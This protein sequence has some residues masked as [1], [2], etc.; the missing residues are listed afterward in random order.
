MRPW[1]LRCFLIASSLAAAMLPATGITAAA[2]ASASCT[3]WPSVRVLADIPHE[4]GAEMTSNPCGAKL[5][6]S[7]Q[8]A[9]PSTMSYSWSPG[10]TV[11]GAQQWVDDTDQSDLA[12][13]WCAYLG[14]KRKCS[15]VS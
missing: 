9:D 12:D 11:K 14:T 3:T 2:P 5:A 7:L 4:Y 15:G 13:G 10:T 6:V 1:I 8:G